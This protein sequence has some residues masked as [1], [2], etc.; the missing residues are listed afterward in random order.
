MIYNSEECIGK[1]STKKQADK[2]AKLETEQTGRK[3]H[4]F[5]THYNSPYGFE[6][7]IHWTIIISQEQ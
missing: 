6:D 1:Y 4:A 5:L 3:H 2:V 7:I